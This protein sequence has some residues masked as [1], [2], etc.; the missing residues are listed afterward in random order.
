M[1][2]AEAVKDNLL[3]S[4]AKRF[5]RYGA[6]NILIGIGL[7]AGFFFGFPEVFKL[8]FNNFEVNDKR[9]ILIA[10][11]ISANFIYFWAFN[12]VFFVIYYFKLFEEHRVQ[13][14]WPWE[15]DPEEWRKLK[16]ETIKVLLTNQ[17]VV[18]PF[19]A[20]LTNL[21][22]RETVRVDHNYPEYFEIFWQ[23]CLCLLLEDFGFYWSHR[24]LHHDKLYPHIHKIHHKY[25][26][27]ASWSSEFAHPIEFIIGNALPVHLGALVLR[28]RMHILTTAMF[29]C[30]RILKT[31][32]AHCGFDFKW[33]PFKMF[34]LAGDSVFHDYHHYKFK[35]NY[36]SFLRFWDRFCSTYNPKYVD[37]VIIGKTDVKAVKE[38]SN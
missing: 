30:L 27:T 7:L 8:I 1:V 20:L 35:G 34:F 36:G 26:V 24:I 29:L 38:K 16:Y 19:L 5:K 22:E 6:V 9:S 3:V 25:K 13:K 11:T 23:I 2:K 12:S 15:G 4:E 10:F 18:I 32:D 33:S 31:T 14:S 37:D 21:R 17:L 28:S